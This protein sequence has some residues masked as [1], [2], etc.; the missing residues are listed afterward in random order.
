VGLGPRRTSQ[1]SHGARSREMGLATRRKSRSVSEAFERT[2]IPSAWTGSPPHF[3]SQTSR[4]GPPRYSWITSTED[5]GGKTTVA[6]LTGR[7]SDECNSGVLLMMRLRVSPGT[8]TRTGVEVPNTWG[9]GIIWSVQTQRI[10]QAAAARHR[11]YEQRASPVFGC[12]RVGSAQT[13][14]CQHGCI[15]RI[16]NRSSSAFGVK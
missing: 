7:G 9:L 12:C 4:M 3:Q 15:R 10:S 1:H 2:E 6:V 14:R 8:R 11:C 13:G 5:D 16:C